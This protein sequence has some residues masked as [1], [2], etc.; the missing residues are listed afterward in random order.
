MIIVRN[1]KILPE[2][3][4]E[5]RRLT[6]EEFK[7]L[8]ERILEDGAIREKIIVWEGTDYIVDGH[9]RYKIAMEYNIPFDVLEMT[10]DDERDARRW[11]NIN[12]ARSKGR[13]LVPNE[14]HECIGRAYNLSK[15]PHG[16]SDDNRDEH[17]YYLSCKDC[18]SG[19]PKTEEVIAKKFGVSERTVHNAAE[20]VKILDEIKE[21]TGPEILEIV[22]SEPKKTPVQYLEFINNEVDNNPVVLEQVFD[23]EPYLRTK[24]IK[25]YR[26]KVCNERND[27]VTVQDIADRFGISKTGMEDDLRFARILLSL[28]KDIKDWIM[29][30]PKLSVENVI[31]YFEDE[32]P[33]TIEAVVTTMITEKRNISDAYKQVKEQDPEALKNFEK[34][35]NLTDIVEKNARAKMKAMFGN[36]SGGCIMPNAF[37]MWCTD[38]EFGFDTFRGKETKFCPYCGQSNI[39]KRDPDWYPEKV[40]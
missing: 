38:C 31:K 34:Y 19:E 28:P 4:N 25:F 39:E 1:L 27:D 10:F 33:N 18:N 12:A 21:K 35:G 29:S 22:R 40:D 7:N 9:H 6:E 37:E 8:T 32:L 17:G 24:W 20:F 15:K 36:S 2:F 13:L 23:T 16:R 3:E 14:R 30:N 26:G 5:I 11:I